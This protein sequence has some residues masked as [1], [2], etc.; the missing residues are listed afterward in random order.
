VLG[1]S[2]FSEARDTNVA[3]I[4][5]FGED[6][7]VPSFFSGQLARSQS[8]VP[9]NI[10]S[11]AFLISY[12]FFLSFFSPSLSP[13]LWPSKIFQKGWSGSSGKCA[14]PTNVRP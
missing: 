9:G 12:I 10:P 6:T 4:L 13:L 2:P 5:S 14:Y 8:K 11:N 7:F 3:M 1:V